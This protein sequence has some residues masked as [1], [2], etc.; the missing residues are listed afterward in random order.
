MV[1]APDFSSPQ[2]ASPFT[3]RYSS[4]DCHVSNSDPCGY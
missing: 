1:G 4:T 2:V 3:N